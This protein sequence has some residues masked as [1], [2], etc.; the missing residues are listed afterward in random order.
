MKWNEMNTATISRPVPMLREVWRDKSPRELLRIFHNLQAGILALED[1]G[2]TEGAAA[3]RETL[4]MVTQLI[5][6]TQ[7]NGGR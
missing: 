1:M 5:D 2:L 6:A 4:V 3:M 7:A